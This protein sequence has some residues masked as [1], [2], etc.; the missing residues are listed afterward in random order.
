MCSEARREVA[1]PLYNPFSKIDRTL[2]PAQG[3]L[4]ANSIPTFSPRVLAFPFI[5][6]HPRRAL[7]GVEISKRRAVTSSSVSTLS[8]AP[9]L[10]GKRLQGFED[11]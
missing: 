8:M 1:A 7:R 2:D 5:H 3:F 4:H 6:L 11:A 10:P 9:P